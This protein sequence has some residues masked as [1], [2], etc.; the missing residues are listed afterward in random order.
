MLKD[1]KDIDTVFKEG[2]SEHLVTPPSYVWDSVEASLNKQK[3][4]S[5]A[6]MIWRSVAAAAA[7]LLLWMS[8]NLLQDTTTL[9]IEVSQQVNLKSLS[10]LSELD[11]VTDVV[12][13][14]VSETSV[15]SKKNGFP[16]MR[17]LVSKVERNINAPSKK[18]ELAKS[19][20]VLEPLASKANVIVETKYEIKSTLHSNKKKVYYPLFASNTPTSQKRKK[21]SIRIGGVLSPAYSSKT[22]SG[23]NMNMA[24]ANGVNVDES[25][26]N[27]LGGG[28]QLR[29]NRGSR[30]S[31]ETG[32]MYAQVGQEVTNSL[33]Q[34]MSDPKA[35]VESAN[36]PNQ[37][38]LTNSMGDIAINKPLRVAYATNRPG[39]FGEYDMNA[40]VPRSDGVKQSLEYLEIPMMARY[41]LF[42]NFP[43]VSLAG[44][45]SS[46]FLV[47]NTAYAINDSQEEEIGKTEGIRPFVISSSVGVGV[48]VPLGKLLH[49]S[50]E[51]RFKYFI[52]SVNSDS[53]YG[54][55]PYSF[56]VYGGITFVIK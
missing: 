38:Q 41:S 9:P 56:G 8:V 42:K 52:N 4:Q 39:D 19:N 3:K 27:S 20:V 15:A 1:R 33:P 14:N 25:G 31:F 2:L 40:A 12:E 54:F 10:T 17:G 6:L 47:G 48:E 34:Y 51:P 5:R 28:I 7:V 37:M 26:V 44:G 22:S 55:Q 23:N 46:N 24:R 45:F 53:E 36:T 21:T 18:S 43:Y 13:T 35:M 50:L 49:F 29:V 30:W 16:E 11:E 32:V